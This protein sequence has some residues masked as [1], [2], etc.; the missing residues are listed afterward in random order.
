MKKVIATA[1][2]VFVATFIAANVFADDEETG[3][4][5][6][7]DLPDSPPASLS[8]AA[9]FDAWGQ[10]LGFSDWDDYLSH[11]SIQGPVS[12]VPVPVANPPQ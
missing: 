11:H 12:P 2:F 3:G 8:S 4:G 5:L 9:D 10:A 1:C 7:A 6:P